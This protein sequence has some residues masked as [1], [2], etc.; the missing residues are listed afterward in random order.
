MLWCVTILQNQSQR[1]DKRSIYTGIYIYVDKSHN[2]LYEKNSFA[3]ISK[4]LVWY[5]SENLFSD[6][7]WL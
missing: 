6:Q 2:H 5:K 7:I 3:E 4:N 1:R